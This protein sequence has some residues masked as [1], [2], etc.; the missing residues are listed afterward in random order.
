MLPGNSVYELA[1]E[2]PVGGIN[3]ITG[4]MYSENPSTANIYIGRFSTVLNGPYDDFSFNVTLDSL[5]KEH[6]SVDSKCKSITKN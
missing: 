1:Q 6:I 3:G 5:T 4:G 2:L